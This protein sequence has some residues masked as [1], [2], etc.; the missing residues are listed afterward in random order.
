MFTFLAIPSTI[1]QCSA[2]NCKDTF[3][4]RKH[5]RAHIWE[6]HSLLSGKPSTSN[7]SVPTPSTPKS[8]DQI[9][10]PSTSSR[11]EVSP[12][13]PLP[14]QCTHPSCSKSFPTNSKRKQHSRT[15]QIG[16]YACAQDHS[17][18]GIQEYLKDWR[19]SKINQDGNENQE[20]RMPEDPFPTILYF[21]SWSKLR[22]HMKS[23]HKKGKFKAGEEEE[24]E[25]EDDFEEDDLKN[26][27]KE[28]NKFECTYDFDHV[29]PPSLSSSLKAIEDD[30]PSL[31][32]EIPSEPC[33]KSF[34]R[35]SALRTHIRVFHLGE[36]RFICPNES[37]GCEKKYAYRHLL[38][39]HEGKCWF[40]V[41]EGK[42]KKRKK[43]LQ[44]EGAEDQNPSSE[45]E[46]NMELINEEEDEVADDEEEDEDED[47]F[48]RKEGG[49]VPEI[50][51]SRQAVISTK[52]TKRK[53]K[54][55]GLL[56]RL[57]GSGYI[58]SSNMI[59]TSSSRKRRRENENEEVEEEEMKEEIQEK[60]KRKN[61]GRVLKCPWE[62]I[63]QVMKRVEKD[64]EE[65]T[66][67]VIE[68]ENVS[69]SLELQDQNFQVLESTSSCQYRFSRMYDLRRHVKATHSLE[70]T[71][72]E[73]R[74]FTPLEER[75]LLPKERK[76]KVT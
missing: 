4:K 54:K 44:V 35:L 65:E 28:E 2:I 48:F 13:I 6:A 49:A 41:E 1:Y 16:R 67:Q 58:P 32:P 20:F 74:E 12:P 19:D 18:E 45:G 46:A 59:G 23:Q 73:L 75:E 53:E 61:R 72:V 47:D 64:D 50:H 40:R 69:S 39:R 70:L 56:N 71:E 43:K 27:G 11:S 25:I 63:E 57:V 7:S 14:F 10:I 9:P 30:L 22:A 55:V 31:E 38:R 42:K 51:S 5:L 17:E 34:S 8:S 62:K 60:K 3:S 37:R 24:E 66:Q 33:R 76:K 29:K 15:H 21:E 52:E 68:N 26:K 36:K